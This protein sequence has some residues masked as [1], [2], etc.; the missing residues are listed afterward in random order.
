M[1]KKL[2]SLFLA[3]TVLLCAAGCGNDASSASVKEDNEITA[4]STEET[5]EEEKVEEES[6]EEAVEVEAEETNKEENSNAE[7]VDSAPYQPFSR[8]RK[9]EIQKLAYTETGYTA[10]S[11]E[12]ENEFSFDYIE[13]YNSKNELISYHEVIY[14]FGAPEGIISCSFQCNE[15]GLIT[16]Y[17][18]NMEGAYQQAMGYPVDDEL[19]RYNIDLSDLY[20][21]GEDGK[22]NRINIVAWGITDDVVIY[23]P[24]AKCPVTGVGWGSIDRTMDW[25]PVMVDIIYEGN[26][27]TAEYILPGQMYDATT[28]ITVD[29]ALYF[30]R[31]EWTYDDDGMLVSDVFMCS[32]KDNIAFA[33]EELGQFGGFQI[34]YVPEEND[35]YY[36]TKYTYDSNNNL[37]AVE[38][39]GN[40][41]NFINEG[42][43]TYLDENGEPY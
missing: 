34:S 42:T 23:C 18:D 43:Y 20:E 24:D 14:G 1:K 9:G 35:Y 8:E 40:V 13:E 28:R 38:R 39:D 11:T 41:S 7:Q 16:N 30:L 32:G 3:T 21:Y 12:L 33:K 26:T 2:L 10:T 5:A 31:E 19:V 15:L 6:K 37:L 4:A 17:Y 25:N 22:I 27:I 29:G 36:I